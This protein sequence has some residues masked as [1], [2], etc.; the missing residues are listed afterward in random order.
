MNNLNDWLNKIGQ[1][2][3][4]C[5]EITR[6]KQVAQKLGIDKTTAKVITVTGTNGKGS[7]VEMLTSVYVNA[8][9]RVGT[10]TSPHLFRFNERVRIQKNPVDDELLCA[11]FNHVEK[12]RDDIALSYFEW[13]T[14]AALWIFREANI[15][16]IILEVGI[17]G[18]LDATNILDADLAIITSIGL[19]HQAYLGDT[20]ELIAQEK[21]GICRQGQWAVCGDA[22]PPETLVQMAEKLGSR[23]IYMGKDF[24]YEVKGENWSFYS[25]VLMENPPGGTPHGDS[26]GSEQFLYEGSSAASIPETRPVFPFVFKHVG[27]P[28]LLVNNAAIVF[29]SILLLNTPAFLPV[30]ISE[31]IQAIITTKLSGR[32]EAKKASNG[33]IIIYDV[34]HNPH[35]ASQLAAFL[36]SYS[37]KKIIA[38]FSMLQDKDISGTIGTVKHL[39]HEWHVAEINHPRRASKEQLQAAFDQHQICPKWHVDLQTADAF[40]KKHLTKEDVEVVFGSFFVVSVLDFNLL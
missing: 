35:A 18:R 39:I 31:A 19:D 28:N 30:N 2:S 7:C 3:G 38:L 10:Y 20:R 23:M 24:S 15:Q 8:G 9:Y 33:A 6:V 13:V 16:V 14:L 32:C 17:G 21:A 26:S 34:A 22:F 37:S 25:E 1:P 36:K 5:R 12:A 4:T 27:L 40:I 11:A 29:Q